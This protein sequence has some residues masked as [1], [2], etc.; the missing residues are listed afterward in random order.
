MKKKPKEIVDKFPVQKEQVLY[1]PVPEQET[2]KLAKPL[3]AKKK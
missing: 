1:A 2:G 3:P